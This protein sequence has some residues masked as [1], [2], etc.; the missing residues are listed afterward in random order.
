MARGGSKGSASG[1][2]DGGGAVCTPLKR[3]GFH[4]ECVF[5]QAWLSV[6]VC[7]RACLGNRQLFATLS[8]DDHTLPPKTCSVIQ[9]N[10]ALQG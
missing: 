3:F 4:C 5:T 7:V 1:C 2:V 6:C 10:V 9:S 8:F